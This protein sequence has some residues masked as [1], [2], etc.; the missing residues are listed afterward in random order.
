MELT[1]FRRPDYWLSQHLALFKHR[2]SNYCRYVADA[3]SIRVNAGSVG[4]DNYCCAGP[5]QLFKQPWPTSLQVGSVM[6]P[7]C[8]QDFVSPEIQDDQPCRHRVS[9]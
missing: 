8:Q 6:D 9:V 4:Y 2:R 5:M 1:S 3:A 7:A